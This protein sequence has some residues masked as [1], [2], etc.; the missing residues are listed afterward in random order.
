MTSHHAELLLGGSVGR[1][2]GPLHIQF[3]PTDRCNLAC[4]F[5]WQ[6]DIARLDYANEVSAERYRE[7]VREAAALGVRRVTVTGGGEPW[8][9]PDATLAL[10]EEGERPG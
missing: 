8:M 9:R 1:M 4:R 7:L 6:R 2:P 10:V 5:C 3:N